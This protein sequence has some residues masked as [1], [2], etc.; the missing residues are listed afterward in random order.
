MKEWHTNLQVTDISQVKLRHDSNEI[1]EL[2][3][4]HSLINS[5]KVG[6]ISCRE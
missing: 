5:M 4:N 6:F 3:L 2:S 1:S